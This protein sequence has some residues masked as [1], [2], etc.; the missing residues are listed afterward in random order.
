MKRRLITA[1][2]GFVCLCLVGMSKADYLFLYPTNDAYVNSVE[3]G[4]VHN[5][6]TVYAGYSDEITRS[7]L[8]FNL[9]AIPNGQSIVSAA[10]RLSPNFLSL[11]DPV[12]GAYYLENDNWSESTLTWNN[13]PTNF[14][15]P[16]TDTKT[17]G[18]EEVFWT[19]SSDVSHAYGDNDIYSVVLKL[20]NEAPP[21]KAGF[22]SKDVG[23]T[24]W[25]P[26]LK[27]EYQPIPEPATLVLLGLGGL[28]L[29]KRQA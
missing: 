3:P 20:P 13:A 24:D 19:V 25:S 1:L 22:W 27:I 29:R 10:L 17:I 6:N 28:I 8:M 12:I 4:S 9:S 21:M 5:S 18:T 16:A 23:V 11:T 15:I 26:Y 2:T 14:K 7:Y